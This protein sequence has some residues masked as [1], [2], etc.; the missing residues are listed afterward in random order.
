M[1]A[2][3][4]WSPHLVYLSKMVMMRYRAVKVSRSD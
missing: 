1:R 4:S 2:L 3:S